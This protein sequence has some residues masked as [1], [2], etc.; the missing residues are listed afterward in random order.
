MRGEERGL[1]APAAEA[2]AEEHERERSLR[3]SG[4]TPR[5]AS[6]VNGASMFFDVEQV[7]ERL[8]EVLR[9][10]VGVARLAPH[11]TAGRRVPD[12]DLAVADRQRRDADRVRA[13]ASR[14][15][16]PASCRPRRRSAATGADGRDRGDDRDE[17]RGELA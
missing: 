8:G 5:Y 6:V 7:L 11:R 15:P 17:C 13:R 2:V 1:L 9:D 12:L 14:T 3:C 4:V 16:R 10:V